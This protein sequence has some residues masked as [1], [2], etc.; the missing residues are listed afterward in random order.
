[1]NSY[2]SLLFA[3]LSDGFIFR[4]KRSRERERNGRRALHLPSSYQ[5]GDD[6]SRSTTRKELIIDR[7][8][9]CRG[10]PAELYR[11]PIRERERRWK[12]PSTFARAVP[13]I[14]GIETLQRPGQS[15]AL[16]ESTGG[17]RH[18]ASG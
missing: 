11:G 10:E 13:W 1:M 6:L 18:Q 5:I 8:I 3:R 15:R 14:G 17:G 7:S 12:Q 16:V 4:Y 9:F 2:L